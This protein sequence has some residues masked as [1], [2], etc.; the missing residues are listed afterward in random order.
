VKIRPDAVQRLIFT[1]ADRRLDARRDGS[2]WLVD[3]RPSG[4]ALRDALDDLV[5]V[6]TSLRAVDRFRAPDDAP[7][8]LDES[9]G[10]LE[11]IGGGRHV[12]LVLG[13]LNAAG[14]AVYAR[15]DGSPRVVLLGAYLLSALDR[16]FYHRNRE[17]APA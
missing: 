16:V 12:R 5:A 14:S 10:T 9:P 2:G 3:G 13:R 17:R 11:V 1:H 7:Y 15:R 6:L 4:A 8:G